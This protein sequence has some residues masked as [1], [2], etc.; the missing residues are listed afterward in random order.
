LTAFRRKYDPNVKVYAFDVNID[1]P[2][3]NTLIEIYNITVVPSILYNDLMIPKYI[4]MDE[5]EEI[6][7]TSEDPENESMQS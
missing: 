4:S 2:A 1:D 5:L 7:N 6:I 3:L